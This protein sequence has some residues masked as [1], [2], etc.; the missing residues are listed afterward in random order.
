MI[1]KE[2]NAMEAKY[3]IPFGSM[4]VVASNDIN[5]DVLYSLIKQDHQI[6]SFGIGTNLVTCQ[7][8]PA[9]G[10]VF[11]L[12]DVNGR[13]RMKLSEDPGKTTTPGRKKIYRL[14][15]KEGYPILDLVMLA[16]EE[17]PKVGERIL[18][19]HIHNTKKRCYCTPSRVEELLVKV[20]DKE[21]GVVYELPP[22][23][24]SRDY[25]LKQL[26][27]AREDHIR[28]MNPTP[29]K[30]SASTRL[31]DYV[32]EIWTSICPIAELE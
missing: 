9:L 15:S 32:N 26:K 30:V 23:K 12:A 20:W 18:C 3:H 27:E 13:P 10:M 24:E 7:G 28:Y 4:I 11:K 22:L 8:Q 25:V 17:A 31:S 21:Q 19:Y 5:V 14:Y 29:Y 2:Y 6:D 16:D 1:H